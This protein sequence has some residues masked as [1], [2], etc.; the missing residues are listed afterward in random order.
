MNF[1]SPAPVPINAAGLVERLEHGDLVTLSRD[2]RGNR[3]PSRPRTDD[4]DALPGRLLHRGPRDLP[5]LALPVRHE[6]LEPT[7]RDR[8]V[9]ALKRLAERTHALALPFLRTH[10]PANRR[11]KVRHLYRVDGL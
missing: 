1:G 3:E 2:V 4:R 9:H 11:E 5:V 6:A 7:D 10:A 8:L